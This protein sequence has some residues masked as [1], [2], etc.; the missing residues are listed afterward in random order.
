MYVFIRF[1]SY[2]LGAIK[3]HS[4]QLTKKDIITIKGLNTHIKNTLLN[5]IKLT[6]YPDKITE[7]NAS[8]TIM[9]KPN[10]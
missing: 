7:K 9:Y 2:H 3:P 1:I 5:N 10:S 8:K 6:T 4:R